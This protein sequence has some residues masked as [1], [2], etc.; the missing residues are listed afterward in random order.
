MEKINKINPVEIGS[1]LS[2]IRKNNKLTQLQLSEKISISPTH[3]ST[4][5]NGGSYSLDT[6]LA[7][8]NGLNTD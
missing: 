8:C 1:T 2:K 3:I 5:E 4:V 6:L 7:I